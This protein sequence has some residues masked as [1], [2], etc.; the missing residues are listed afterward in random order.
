MSDDVRIKFELHDDT[1]PQNPSEGDRGRLPSPDNAS[2]PNDAN[3][4]GP[5]GVVD[6]ER[7]YKGL[8][9]MAEDFG[10]GELAGGIAGIMEVAGPAGMAL[11]L[12][13]TVFTAKV[14]FESLTQRVED[15]IAAMAPFSGRIQAAQS[16]A[17]VQMMQ[18]MFRRDAAVGSSSVEFIHNQNRLDVALADLETFLQTWLTPFMSE[19]ISALAD[20]LEMI[21]S[22]ANEMNA[23]VD[24]ETRKAGYHVLW[25]VFMGNLPSIKRILWPDAGGNPIDNVNNVLNWMKTQTVNPRQANQAP[26]RNLPAGVL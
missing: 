6:A 7:A 2:L 25:Q 18:A 5:D 9:G 11:G 14:A 13:T 26:P 17:E 20:V 15:S 23:I 24:P 10:F 1:Q 16:M 21:T 4:V 22:I 8:A 19:G 12:L 3:S